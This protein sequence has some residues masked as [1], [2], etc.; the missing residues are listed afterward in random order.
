ME[1]CVY[2]VTSNKL[3]QS[4]LIKIMLGTY[5]Q[6]GITNSILYDF[7]IISIVPIYRHE[8][9]HIKFFI[10]SF[11]KSLLLGIKIYWKAI[12]SIVWPI[13]LLPL[14]LVDDSIPKRCLYVVLLMAGFWIT[15]TI[16]HTIV[17]IFPI[18][19]FP[20]LNIMSTEEACRSY[21]ADA[22]MMFVSGLILAIAV[23]YCH[24][25]ERIALIVMNAIGCSPRRL[26]LGMVIITSFISLWITN[27]ATTAI[28]VPIVS[29]ILKELEYN[30]ILSL[31]KTRS[32]ENPEE[33][34]EDTR[35]PTKA[36]LCYFV[37]AAYASSIGGMGTIIG[38]GTNLAF[39]G[40]YE[41]TFKDAP[42]IDFGYFML[43]TVPFVVIL[44]CFLTI[45]LQIWYLGLFRPNSAD[46]KNINIGK[47]GERVA[48]SVI[49]YKLSQLGPMSFHE[50]GVLV[51]FVLA[52]IL[53]VTRAPQA[54]PGWAELVT[55]TKVKDS[56]V[57]ILVI[58]LMFSI[59]EK[60]EF[61]YI[62]SE[63]DEKMPKGPSA[64]LLTWKII[65]QKMPWGLVFL[66]GSGFALSNAASTSK[67]ND[68]VVS[69]LGKLENFPPFVVLVVSCV[70]IGLI[71]Q[72]TSNVAIANITLPIMAQLARNLK[73]HPLY[74]MY[75]AC[76][77]CSF[78]FMLPVSTPPNA[79][80]SAPCN[81]PTLQM[82]IIG[83]IT[84]II[85]LLTLFAVVPFIGGLVWNYGT[86]PAWADNSYVSENDKN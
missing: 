11:V 64:G 27:T 8:L 59:P 34:K 31:Y 83:F 55:D 75:P 3:P 15:E 58:M 41:T 5:M 85:S 76:L 50:K 81:M 62:F 51:C 42:E 30:G 2:V 82:I 33:E 74:L 71:T 28:M 67:M 24:L 84:L 68:Y 21:M 61:I 43:S 23:E 40:L 86:F 38:T 20:L 53:W 44:Q 17:S 22:T 45:T 79:I 46:A 54:F 14:L 65:Q 56:T 18:V 72:F 9:S 29:S 13:I 78:A 69:Y 6:I 12:F 19:L 7:Y 16:H 73:I 77:T 1:F 35:I 70:M 4:S 36:T 26:H 10:M 57:A 66:I 32:V 37:T 52:I 39:K 80:A 49:E 48:K 63:D 25:H 47:E 60:P